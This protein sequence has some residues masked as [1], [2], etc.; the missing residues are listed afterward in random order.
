MPA[1]PDELKEVVNTK[2][3]ILKLAEICYLSTLSSLKTQLRF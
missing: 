3:L 2:Y 1:N